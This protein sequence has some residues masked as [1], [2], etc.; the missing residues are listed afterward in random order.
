MLNL[1]SKKVLVTGGSRGIGA[2]CVKYFC[3]A[4]ASVAFTY[5]SS[6]CQLQQIREKIF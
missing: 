3:M 1:S 5:K 6:P 2:A 4:G